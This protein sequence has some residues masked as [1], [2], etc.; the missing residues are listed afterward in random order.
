[1]AEEQAGDR[2]QGRLGGSTSKLYGKCDSASATVTSLSIC[3]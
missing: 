3:Q 1:M 2:L